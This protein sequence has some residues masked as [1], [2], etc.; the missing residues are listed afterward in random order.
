[1]DVIKVLVETFGAD[2]S[3][4]PRL[5][6][7]GHGVLPFSTAL[8]ALAI[9]GHWWQIK[10]M[11]YLL[12][13]GADPE[14]EDQ[15]GCNVLHVAITFGRIYTRRQ[16]VELLLKQGSNPNAIDKIGLSC[17]NKAVKD[18]ELMSMLIKQG[19]DVN[20]GIKPAI[21]SAIEGQQTD[22]VALLLESGANPNS[23]LNYSIENRRKEELEHEL[24]PLLA[25]ASKFFDLAQLRE[26]STVITSLLLHKCANPYLIFNNSKEQTTI[27]H[28][29]LEH[30]GVLQAFF[31]TP[32]L[33]LEHRDP[34]G[35]TLLLAACQSRFATT[36]APTLNSNEQRLFLK[37]E[38][39]EERQAEERAAFTSQLIPAHKLY[40]LGSNLFVQDNYG[41]N[42]L[43][44][45]L[46]KT[47]S[48]NSNFDKAVALFIKKGPSL[49]HQKNKAGFKP[50]HIAFRT[51]R[52][53]PIKALLSAGGDINE[54]DPDGNAILHFLA[55]SMHSSNL[56]EELT[57][58]F[59]YFLSLGVSINWP[60]SLG[61][62]P[63]FWYFRSDSSPATPSVT[64]SSEKPSQPNITTFLDTGT[65]LFHKNNEGETLLHIVAGRFR[66]N[67]VPKY[68]S[69]RQMNEETE[70][71]KKKTKDTVEEFKWLL[72][73][74]L[75]PMV[76]DMAHRT[77]LDV[78]AANGNEGILELFRS[79]AI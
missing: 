75:D 12:Q 46:S 21:F 22:A 6:A 76:E 1:L 61:E 40:E 13:R 72:G 36:E 64:A 11:E 28:H 9:E 48:D 29:L 47:P 27:I 39:L 58:N 33:Q 26:R 67:P 2:I 43:H 65:D 60:N 15:N 7:P 14:L 30:G 8:H 71:F 16:A 59:K 32:D 78:A 4:Q 79:D 45:L 41:N 70:L 35:R 20:L 68:R 31:E 57:S 49:I 42:A 77:P 5:E 54:A 56:D 23:R 63:I 44:L 55:Q 19:A 25:A 50:L 66:G 18:V 24:Y 62:T 10:A 17:L 53:W 38:D 51:K 69:M 52:I 37:R 3:Y 34:Q 73:K 74:G